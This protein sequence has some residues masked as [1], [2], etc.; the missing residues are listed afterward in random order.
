M[1]VSEEY[2]VALIG[3]GIAEAASLASNC[4][5]GKAIVSPM[6]KRRPAS[7][8]VF[9]TGATVSSLRYLREVEPEMT[10]DMLWALPK[11][12]RP[13]G[14]EFRVKSP[15]SLARKIETRVELG[16]YDSTSYE[17]AERLTDL[18]RYTGVCASP[19]EVV[20][21]AR[22]TLR[23][24]RR[25]GWEVVEAEH[26]YVDDNP[27]KGLHVLVRDPR[28]GLT[29]EVQF[30]SEQ[31]QEV[32]DRYHVQYEIARDLSRPAAVRNEAD[33]EMRRAWSRV[34][35]PAGIEELTGLCG[36]PV[37]PKRYVRRP[38]SRGRRGG[39]G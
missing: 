21:M 33:D 14:L 7:C 34:P 23:R 20:P 35:H 36:V 16:D 38:L 8:E 24:L 15:S 19:D 18:V 3:S 10:I 28:S 27:Y 11:E 9:R 29:I 32:K 6:P 31:S 4:D 12:A 13:H 25:R 1:K 37:K 5:N 22:S 26:S 17:I 30:H 2:E 39:D